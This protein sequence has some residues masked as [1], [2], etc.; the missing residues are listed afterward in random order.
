MAMISIN[1]FGFREEIARRGIRAVLTRLSQAGLDGFEPLLLGG[2]ESDES[3]A[4]AK[5]YGLWTLSGA[6]ELAAEEFLGLAIRTAHIMPYEQGRLVD[7]AGM[8][9]RLVAFHDVLG[10]T[11][12]ITS[13]PGQTPEEFHALG[14][15]LS[16]VN[17]RL[18]G[19]P[20][21]M[22]F[23][24]HDNEFRAF[25]G[26]WERP[27]DLVREEAGEQF[28]FQYDV[29]WGWFSGADE[30]ELARELAPHIV[31]LHFK[32]F[33]PEVAALRGQDRHVLAHE[34]F[35]AIGEGPVRSDG[36]VAAAY[37]GVF[38]RW[39][40]LL[41]IDQDHSGGDPYEDAAAGAQNLRRMAASCAS[42][43]V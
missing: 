35:V 38:P 6:R 2:E 33:R 8:A 13:C 16:A 5:R 42:A 30:V 1:A 32:G 24:A 11:E 25:P 31:S 18:E 19:T 23:H 29:G 26:T 17:E 15:F 9:D 28:A 7:P 40:G 34:D 4:A 36:L 41:I 20:C 10:A 14:R 27:L 22:L 43:G 21:T 37:A 3:G 39:N 12:F